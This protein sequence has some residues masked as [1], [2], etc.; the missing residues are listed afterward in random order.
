MDIGLE[1]SHEVRVVR[2]HQHICLRSPPT[3][4]T[5]ATAYA[6]PRPSLSL[7]GRP[8]ALIKERHHRSLLQCGACGYI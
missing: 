2:F 4:G 5:P 3:P 8:R 1:P 6:S 7:L